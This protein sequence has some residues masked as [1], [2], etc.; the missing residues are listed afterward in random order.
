MINK[1]NIRIGVGS[2]AQVAPP[3]TVK[4]EALR[5]LPWEVHWNE[6]KTQQTKLSPALGCAALSAVGCFLIVISRVP[7]EVQKFILLFV[8]YTLAW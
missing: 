4:N 6:T 8:G 1:Q 5:M 2:V 3:V 7:L